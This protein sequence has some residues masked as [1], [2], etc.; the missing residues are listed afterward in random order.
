MRDAVIGVVREEIVARDVR[1]DV[2]RRGGQ[3]S[4]DGD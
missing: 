1:H 2:R 3:C 4:S